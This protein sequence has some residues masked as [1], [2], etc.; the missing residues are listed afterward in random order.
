M[1]A[2]RR[3]LEQVEAFFKIGSNTRADVLQARVRLG[4]TQL[5]RITATNN[6]QIAQATLASLLNFGLQE[7]FSIDGSLDI[8]E[9]DPDFEAEV[10]YMLEHRSDLN[11]SRQRVDASQSGITVAERSR[12]PTLAASLGYNWND[13]VWPDNGNFFRQNYFWNIGL[14][15][16]WDIFDRFASKSNILAAKASSRGRSPS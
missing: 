5:D 4:N 9:V 16:N 11:A 14:I 8:T 15:V 10:Q 6:E 2:A 12:W 7:E 3:N 13:R 1:G